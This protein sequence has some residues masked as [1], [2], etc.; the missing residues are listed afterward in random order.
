M[1]PYYLIYFIVIYDL[2]YTIFITSKY[3]KYSHLFLILII[4]LFSG[5]RVN[6][7]F[8]F[9]AYDDFFNNLPSYNL[10]DGFLFYINSMEIGYYYLNY[11]VNFLGLSKQIIYLLGSIFCIFSFSKLIRGE[12]N[13]YSIIL[14]TYV[15]FNLI[16]NHFSLLRQSFA[17]G[18]AY[19]SYSSFLNSGKIK[20]P[21]IY[22]LFGFFFHTS[23]ILYLII[24]LFSNI[25]INK[26]LIITTILFSFLILIF[27][28]DLTYVL[29]E[30][31]HNNSS[32]SILSTKYSGYADQFSYAPK[33]TFYFF[34]LLNVFYIYFSLKFM[35]I[36]TYQDRLKSL[37]LY[38]TL[39]LIIIMTLFPSNY[40]LYNRLA[41]VTIVL[42]S[43]LF[44]IYISRKSQ[45][46]KLI[47]L[48]LM[49]LIIGVKFINEMTSMSYGLNPYRS[50]FS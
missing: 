4:A 43:Y 5:L 39:F 15:S 32:L 33:F 42:Q 1:F 40:I 44:S 14:L 47:Y 31:I 3:K 34:Y 18:F 27:K 29:L 49:L 24:L 22:L 21:F 13:V 30:Y 25:K 12:K 6:T 35:S 41:I 50:I 20:R 8:D 37:V 9:E 36:N 45:K 11:F 7:G 38:S 46:F 48:T 16:Q 28:I 17:V 19:L 10:K 26:N 23:T 2:Y